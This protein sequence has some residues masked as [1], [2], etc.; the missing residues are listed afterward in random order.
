[1]CT[2]RFASSRCSR[3]ATRVVGAFGYDR[4]RGQFKIFRAKAVVLATGG[5]GKAYKITSNSW[6]CTGDGHSLAYHAGAE[7]ID[8]EYHSVSS[9]RHGLAA[10]RGGNAR[11][12]RR[13]RRRRDSHEQ[14]TA[15]VSCSISFRTTTKRRRPTTRKKA[16]VIRRATRTR[17]A[18][19]NCSRAITWRVASC[20][21]SRKGG[22]LR[23][24]A[25]ISTS[26]GSRKKSRTRK[27]TSNAS[28]PSMYHQFKRSATWTSRSEA[29]GGRADHALHH[30]RRACG[31]GHADV[32]MCPGLFAAGECAAGINGANRLG[33][34]SLSDL[35]SS[36]NAPANSRRSSRRKIR[37]A[38]S[39]TIRS[40]C[41]R[42]RSARSHSSNSR[43]RE[44]VLRA[45]RFAGSDAAQCRHRA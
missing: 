30:G 36:A 14:P 17:A 1:M 29:D 21:R 26:R 31:C 41:S 43:R 6:D 15:N 34:N 33:G 9:H 40:T 18:R 8:M 11:D 24:A 45:A 22:G 19:R 5:I 35:L 13:A 10:E 12:R 44:S 16:G 37:T 39:T 42:A 4:E 27:S 7:L 38:K 20:A 32:A 23:M 28:C 25:S 3:M 2:W